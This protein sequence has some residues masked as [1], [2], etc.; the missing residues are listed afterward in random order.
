MGHITAKKL[1]L[2]ISR[3]LM[4]IKWVFRRHIITKSNF[5]VLFHSHFQFTNSNKIRKHVSLVVYNVFGCQ[6]S[7]YS[8][9][10]DQWL[11]WFIQC[12]RNIW[13]FRFIASKFMVMNFI[14]TSPFNFTSMRIRFNSCVH[15]RPERNTEG[16]NRWFWP[17]AVIKVWKY[18]LW[19]PMK[20]NLRTFGDIRFGPIWR[21]TNHSLEKV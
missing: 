16:I 15:F 20:L 18:P 12:M 7:Q 8:V 3:L 1:L 2:F 4:T 14:V 9:T 21:F 5:T 19:P 6:A 17:Q 10:R 11:C 13:L